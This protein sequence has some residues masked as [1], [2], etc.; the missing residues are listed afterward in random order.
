MD[1]TEGGCSRGSTQC[2]PGLR[3]NAGQPARNR[4]GVAPCTAWP[5]ST[6]ASNNL[7]K[8]GIVLYQKQLFRNYYLAQNI[9]TSS[10]TMNSVTERYH[11]QD[12][13]IQEM[14]YPTPPLIYLTKA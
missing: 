13:T 7:C 14:K 8:K 6:N 3:L 4:V 5:T 11:K 1:L 2:A 10:S 9:H 12:T